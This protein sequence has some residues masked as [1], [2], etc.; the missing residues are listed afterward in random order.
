MPILKRVA[1]GLGIAAA[2]AFSSGA[3]P[4]RVLNVCQLIQHPD[5]WEGKAVT[6]KGAL[7]IGF[8]SEPAIWEVPLV[9]LPNEPCNYTASKYISADERPEVWLA[10]PDGHFRENPPPLFFV[11]DSTFARAAKKLRTIHKEH[12]YW[13]QAIV[14]IDGFVSLRKYNVRQVEREVKEKK[15]RPPEHTFPPVILTVG[16]YRSLVMR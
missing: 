11:N 8:W 5:K 14:V 7:P 13:R 15:L 2:F 4:L 6:V 9:P 12:P 1:Y 3:S 10:L 16:T